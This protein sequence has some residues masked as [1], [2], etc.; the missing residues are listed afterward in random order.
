MKLARQA[1]RR[2]YEAAAQVV[3]PF[4]AALEQDAAKR[5]LIAELNE[6]LANI[7]LWLFFRLAV[8]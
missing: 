3:T 6:Q 1:G 5:C 2:R 7:P 8:E 4:G